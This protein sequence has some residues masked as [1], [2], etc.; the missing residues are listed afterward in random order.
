MITQMIDLKALMIGSRKVGQIF[1]FQSL[2]DTF[3]VAIHGIRKLL[4]N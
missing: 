4:I 2:D 3:M 1:F